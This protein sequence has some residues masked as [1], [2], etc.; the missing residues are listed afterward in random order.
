MNT[1]TFSKIQISK[2]GAVFND[3]IFE[4]ESKTLII[5]M[6]AE[7]NTEYTIFIPKTVQSLKDES[8]KSAKADEKTITWRTEAM[9]KA[10]TVENIKINGEKNPTENIVA[11]ETLKVEV[12]V[13]NTGE[14][15]SQPVALIV[16]LFGQDGIMKYAA[17]DTANIKDTNEIL[18]VEFV[19]PENVGENPTISIMVWDS[20]I[21]MNA[22]R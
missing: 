2:K 11:G 16:T 15:N 18:S 5:K 13:K 14:L 4:V 21:T 3:Y 7:Y 12:D 6:D 8:G 20:I 9:P 19:I 1:D 22:M 17:L 10:I